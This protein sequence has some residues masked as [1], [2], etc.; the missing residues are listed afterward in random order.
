MKIAI[1]SDLHT[2]YSL[3]RL[4]RLDEADLL[5]LAGDI[6]DNYSLPHF[7]NRLRMD[8]PDLPVLYILGN[9]DRWGYS[10]ADGLALHRRI[11]ADYNV[12][13]LDNEA[14]IFQDVLFC[15]TTLWTDFHL[16][17]DEVASKAWAQ[18]LP[19]FRDIR[20]ADGSAISPDDM[21]AMCAQACAFLQQTLRAETAVRKRVVIS[22]FLPSKHLVAPQHAGSQQALIQSAYWTSDLPALTALADVWI[23]GHSH[24]NIET[25]IGQ[26]RFISNQRGY[27]RVM[28][29]LDPKCTGYRSDYIIEV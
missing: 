11:A 12:R 18:R 25:V 28:N 2:E 27:A 6:G 8:A 4:E 9:H 20:Y 13:L 16:A 15:G 14:V 26:T 17:G 24:S 5:I 10:L 7:F 23:Y 29:G 19:D 22:H 3:C 1:H 21:Q